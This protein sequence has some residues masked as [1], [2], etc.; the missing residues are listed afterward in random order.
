M[1]ELTRFPYERDLLER[2]KPIVDERWLVTGEI[3]FHWHEF[4]ELD[5]VLSGSG[6]TTINETTYPFFEGALFFMTPTDRHSYRYDQPAHVLNVVFTPHSI[7]N[8][9]IINKLLS[10][11]FVREQIPPEKLSWLT[12]IIFKLKE[13][14]EK[15]QPFDRPYMMNLLS[16]LL[17]EIIR[18]DQRLP[19]EAKDIPQSVH[20]AMWYMQIHFREE[21]TLEQVAKYVSKNPTYLSELFC[22][23]LSC[24]FKQ[25]LLSLRLEYAQTLLRYTKLSS[26]DISFY[27]GFNS[28]SYFT[29]A[30][31]K[32]YH[33]TPIRYRKEINKS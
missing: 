22:R 12:S 5:L 30:F 26:T 33:V 16:A 21:L 3:E 32:R 15:E 17:I 24:S 6:T 18:L 31:V 14:T 23:T 10:L 25:Y 9:A 29:K 8:P 27:A 19:A 13:E 1:K 20:D 7:E 28:V 4:Y 11:R 2:H